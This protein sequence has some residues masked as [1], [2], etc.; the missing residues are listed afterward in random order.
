M[1]VKHLSDGLS[2]VEWEVLET[3]VT[4]GGQLSPQN[5]AEEHGRHVDSVRQA[6]KRILKLVV[7]EYGSVS[8]RSNHVA[9]MVYDAVQEAYDVTRRTVEAGAKALRQRSVESASNERAGRMCAKYGVDDRWEARVM[10]RLCDVENVQ[11]RLKEPYRRDAI[12]RAVD[13][14]A[15][16][17]TKAR[18]E[19]S[20]IGKKF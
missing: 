5:I 20:R 18:S 6:L 19:Q 10:F 16:T 4:V 9:E 8:L 13:L 11:A 17:K 7:S 1:I 12:V 3:L 2:L 15:C 14:Y